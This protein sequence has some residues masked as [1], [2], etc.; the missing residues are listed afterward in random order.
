MARVSATRSSIEQAAEEHRHGEGGGLALRYPASREALDEG[1]DLRRARASPPSRLLR[2]IS[3][4]RAS[5][6]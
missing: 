4:G 3:C 2:M 6:Q 5:I 1:F